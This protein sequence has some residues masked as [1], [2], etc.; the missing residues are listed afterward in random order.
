[1]RVKWVKRAPGKPVQHSGQTA[2]TPKPRRPIG[3]PK[4]RVPIK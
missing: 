1:M 3:H 4:H 2:A